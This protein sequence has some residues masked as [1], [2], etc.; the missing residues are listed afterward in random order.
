[1]DG[2]GDLP[3]T[4]RLTLGQFILLFLGSKHVQITSKVWFCHS[5]YACAVKT[6]NFGKGNFE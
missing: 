6:I 4:K 3:A 2:F 1:M 5:S